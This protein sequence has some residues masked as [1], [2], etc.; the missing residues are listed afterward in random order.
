MK[1]TVERFAQDAAKVC[2][3]RTLVEFARTGRACAGTMAS[4]S[5][6]EREFF[7]GL[8]LAIAISFSTT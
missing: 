6:T 4:W 7:E 8:S 2:T 5:F 1:L 3:L